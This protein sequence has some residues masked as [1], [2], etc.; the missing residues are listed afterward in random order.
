MVEFDINTIIL[1]ILFTKNHLISFWE[2][3]IHVLL[4]K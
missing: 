4:E 2:K 1:E 3:V